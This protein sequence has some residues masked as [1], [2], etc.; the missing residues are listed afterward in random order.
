MMF[1]QSKVRSMHDCAFAVTKTFV[2]VDHT[3]IRSL[4]TR[5]FWD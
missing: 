3:I 1:A 2:R 4:E 5:L